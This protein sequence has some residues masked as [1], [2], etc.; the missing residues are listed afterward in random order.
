M[1]NNKDLLLTSLFREMNTIAPPKSCVNSLPGRNEFKATF[2]I[3]NFKK[4][5]LKVLWYIGC[6]CKL[7]KIVHNYKLYM[8]VTCQKLS[9]KHPQL[10]KYVNTYCVKSVR[11]RSYSGPHFP[12]FGLNKERYFVLH[13]GEII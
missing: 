9:K 5:V 4:I 12:G 6:F 13:S 1:I 10:C 8:Y 7:Q 3:W 2:F 11:I